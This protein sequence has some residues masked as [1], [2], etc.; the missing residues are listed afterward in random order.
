ML[1]NVHSIH[2]PGVICS[3]RG[4]I[5]YVVN[6]YIETGGDILTHSHEDLVRQS[7]EI[8]DVLYEHGI[9]NRDVNPEN[10]V[11]D[12]KGVLML[13]DYGWAVFSEKDFKKSSHANIEAML[14]KKYRNRDGSFDDAY[15]FYKVLKEYVGIDA[16]L[17]GDISA[18]IGRLRID[19][20][21][22]N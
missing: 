14:N 7:A 15:S 1:Q 2:I 4:E 3:N 10:L 19:Y 12:S 13:I 9:I 8:L 22:P 20:C 6:R 18:R 11:I 17:L 21:F 16:S 5:D